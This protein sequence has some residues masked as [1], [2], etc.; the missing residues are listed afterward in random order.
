MISPQTRAPWALAPPKPMTNLPDHFSF[1]SMST[2]QQCLRKWRFHYID[3]AHPEFLSSS[4]LFGIAVHTA[5]QSAHQT[6]LNGRQPGMQTVM[7]AYEESWKETASDQDIRFGKNEDA[8]K[9]RDMA[10]S[11]FGQFLEQVEPGLDRILAIEEQLSLTIPGMWVP[12]V[13][14]LDLLTETDDC[15]IVV[16]T[17][18]ARNSFTDKVPVATGQL[19]LYAEAM[20][21]MASELDKPFKG[22]FVVFRK[23]KS[24]KIEVVDVP[25]RA[26]EKAH[27]VAMVKS[28]WQLITAAEKANAFPQNPGPFCKGCQ[29][30][31]RC[32][33][34]SVP[35]P[36]DL[37]QAIAQ[38]RMR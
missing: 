34:E 32:A 25:V 37:G 16:D 5:V 9:M 6:R 33:R 21:P 15:L 36:T 22:R 1:S 20:S 13:G 23:L 12:V 7:E 17:K 35:C 31:D 18:T 30:K 38:G 8:A 14:R 24:P 2:A 26:T 27:A 19:A 28:W 4:L 10:R 3:K 29:Y 11:L